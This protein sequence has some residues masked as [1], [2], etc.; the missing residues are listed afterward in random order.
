MSKKTVEIPSDN[1]I[2]ENIVDS[3]G[4]F[5]EKAEVPLTY[6]KRQFLKS[7][8]YKKYKDL[9][10]VLLEDNKFYEKTEVSKMIDGYL[11][12]KVK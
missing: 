11:K 12:G 8:E 7:E 1:D 5:S 6:S 9:L 3:G 2:I 4:T 10:N